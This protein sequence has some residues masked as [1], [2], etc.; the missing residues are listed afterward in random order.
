[1]FEYFYHE[2]L[3]KTVI[4]FGTLFN[5]III[6]KTDNNDNTVSALKVPLAYGPTQKFLARLEQVPD[7]NKPVQMTLPRMSFEFNGLTYDP[8]RKTTATKTFISKDSSN[9]KTQKK[10]YMPVPYNMR[11]ELSIL[12]KTNEDALQ[13]IEQILPYFQ[14]SYNL[15]ITMIAEINE[16]KDIPIQLENISMDDQYEGDYSTRTAIVY[17]LVFTAKT[18]LFGPVQ[19]SKIIKKATVDVMTGIDRPK[20]EMR[21][22]VTPRAIKDYN[23]DVVTTLSEDITADERYITVDSAS[24]IA[25]QTYIYVNSEEMYVEKITGNKLTVK[26]GQDSST[27]DQHVRG[28]AVKLITAADDALIDIG[29]DF[30][31]NESTSF[32]QDFKEFSPTL[33]TD[34]NPI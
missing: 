19:D 5:N 26:R 6:K 11:F 15:T 17:T 28:S 1:M 13:I 16:K 12:S 2:L 4:G 31:F 7:L 33:N 18:H 14:P 9:S 27:A 32:F 34:V 30:G 21:Y 20:R 24:A 8:T 10:T 3:R 23:D 29:D 22:T 25:A